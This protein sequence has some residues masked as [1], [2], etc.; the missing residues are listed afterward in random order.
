L[1][2][3]LLFSVKSPAVFGGGVSVCAP[4]EPGKVICVC[5]AERAGNL[6]YRNIGIAQ[7]LERFLQPEPVDILNDGLFFI[8][9]EKP[10]DMLL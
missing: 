10:D 1:A 9:F 4:I 6:A 7:H 3:I 8:C 2:A 5:K